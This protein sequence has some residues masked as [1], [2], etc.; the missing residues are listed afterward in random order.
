MV[1]SF[2]VGLFEW[3]ETEY[4]PKTKQ[5]KKKQERKTLYKG[6]ELIRSLNLIEWN[7]YLIP[8]QPARIL[9]PKDW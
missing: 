6:Y 7:K 2:M 8:N 1:F 9:A 5:T 4:Q 3:I